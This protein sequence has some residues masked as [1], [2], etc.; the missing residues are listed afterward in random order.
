MCLLATAGFL[1]FPFSLFLFFF[2]FPLHRLITKGKRVIFFFLR[3]LF[4]F[5]F[6]RLFKVAICLGVVMDQN[7]I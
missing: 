3:L 6:Y 4:P 7:I 5:F 1:F 2:F